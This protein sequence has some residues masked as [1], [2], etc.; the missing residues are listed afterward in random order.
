MDNGNIADLSFREHSVNSKFV[1]VFAKR[2]GNVIHGILRRILLAEK[3]DVVIC[4]VDCGAHKIAGR[5]IKTEIVFIC[6]LFMKHS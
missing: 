1:V 4:T 3:G 5:S 2:A 6:V